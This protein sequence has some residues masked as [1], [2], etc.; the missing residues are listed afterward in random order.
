MN[1]RDARRR[2]LLGVALVALL[3]LAAVVLAEVINTVV[4]AV[5][6]AYVL[7]PPRQFLVRRGHSE[8]A[9]TAAVTAGAG[10]AVAALV[11]P[12]AYVVYRRR[13]DLVDLVRSLPDEIPLEIGGV[14]YVV[15]TTGVVPLL[16]AFLQDI[17]LSG[18]GALAVLAFKAMVF[19]LVVYGVLARPHAA[20]RAVFGLVPERYHDIVVA[21]ND[22]TRATLVG[23][24]VVQ[25]ATAV[26]TAILAYAVFGLLGY[27]SALTLAIAAGVLQFVPV[28][29]P[30]VVVGALAVVDLVQGNAPRATLVLLVGLVVVGFLP[31][32]VLRPRLAGLAAHLPVAL[33]FVGFVGGVLTLGAVGFVVGPLVV[34]LLVETVEL[35]SASGE[36]PAPSADL[37]GGGSGDV[38]ADSGTDPPDS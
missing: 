25:A 6:V 15:D 19:A 20:T 16:Q 30:S 38:A 29:G 24:Y 17:A 18:A 28:I 7:F 26:A 21:Y 12:A 13:S 9:A 31:D 34:A 35:L 4:F 14:S 22:R 33:Y 37:S 11:V 36:H 1:D 23:L 3:V 5:T 2:R 27:D 10:L 8:R 32:A